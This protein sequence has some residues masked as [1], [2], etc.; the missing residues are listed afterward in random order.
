MEEPSEVRA[1]WNHIRVIVGITE[2]FVV[3]GDAD[4]QGHHLI[5]P[6]E[7]PFADSVSQ[8]RSSFYAS[9][10]IFANVFVQELE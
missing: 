10:L 4:R 3:A 2:P 7:Q 1:V 5:I 8:C 9:F 6:F